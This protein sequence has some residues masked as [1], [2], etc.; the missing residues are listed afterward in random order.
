MAGR[1]T[2]RSRCW[3][4]FRW[5]SPARRSRFSS[6]EVADMHGIHLV[7]DVLDAQ[8]VDC[9]LE[10]IG[11]VDALVLE[12]RDGEPPRVATILV[13]GAVRAERAGAWMTA[14]H[15]AIRAVFRVEAEGVSRIPFAAVRCVADTIQVELEKETTPSEHLERWLAKHI[16]CRIPGAGGEKK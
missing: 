13:G 11:R 4:F 12:L 16:V 15:R 7:H 6:R 3:P 8:L 14:I 10:K 2:R 5:S 1:A 9:K